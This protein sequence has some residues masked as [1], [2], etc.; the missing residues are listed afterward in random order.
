[1]K[2]RKLFLFILAIIPLGVFAQEVRYVAVPTSQDVTLSS[3]YQ[4][5]PQNQTEAQ[6]NGLIRDTLKVSQKRALNTTFIKN[7]YRDNWFISI[8]GGLGLLMSEESKFAG[9]GNTV[10]PTLAFSFGKWITPVV[11]ARFNFTMAK[12]Q[13]F[14]V[15]N[16]IDRS[17]T[18]SWGHG[19]WYIGRNYFDALEFYQ[20]R[21]FTNTYLDATIGQTHP[22]SHIA[23]GVGKYI[24]E[25]YLDMNRPRNTSEAGSGYDYFMTYAAGSIDLM[26]SVTN[27]FDKYR[28]KRFFDLNLFAGAG[29]AHTLKESKW[30]DD[31]AYRTAIAGGA[32]PNDLRYYNSNFPDI[33][34][35]KHNAAGQVDRSKT[36]VN[37]VMTKLGM[38]MSFRLTDQVSF[39]VE[40]QALFVPEIFDRM[41]GDGNTQDVV[42]NGLVGFTYKFKER[43][44]YEPLCTSTEKIVYL[45]PVVNETRSDCCDDI[46]ERLDR[47]ENLLQQQPTPQ[48]QEE[49]EHLKVTIFFVIDKWNVRPS[50]MYKL[51]EISSFM[52]RNP[53]VRV[54]ISGYA[55]IQTAYPAYNKRLSERRA[56]EVARILTTRFGIDKNRLRVSFYGDTVQPFDVNELNRA[57]IA[58]DIPEE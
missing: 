23:I 45:N 15:W 35:G 51:E 22:E 14:N 24:E 40:A 16:H 52:A 49:I 13:G 43:H 2:T 6:L 5:Q 25:T 28:P 55:D 44:F 27:L 18:A 31:P 33:K 42:L 12:L 50:E 26:L 58:F 37:S 3:A 41:A 20:G 8:G 9:Y 17:G 54:S 46:L 32:N 7:R 57:V 48:V 39:N 10:K 1:M 47:L 29:L 30:I 36:A 21:S 4:Q 34:P 38:E 19:D 11:G 53:K 56:E